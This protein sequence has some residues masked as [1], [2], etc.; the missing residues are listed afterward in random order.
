MAHKDAVGTVST[1]A[2]QEAGLEGMLERVV[3]KWK[4]A[5][6]TIN[7]YKEIKDAFI[8]VGRGGEDAGGGGLDRCVQS[9]IGGCWF[10]SDRIAYTCVHCLACAV[11]PS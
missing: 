6:F 10:K 2:T 9:D 4:A 1:E 3:D 8:L 5:E 11:P 7:P